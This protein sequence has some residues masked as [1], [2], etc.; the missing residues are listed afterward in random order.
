MKQAVFKSYENGGFIFIMDDG[1][2]MFFEEIHPKVIHQYDLINNLEYIDCEFELIYSTYE[3]SKSED[4]IYYRI[5][6]LK[7]VDI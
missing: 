7:L 5:E 1:F 4:A 3:D 2:D 6:K